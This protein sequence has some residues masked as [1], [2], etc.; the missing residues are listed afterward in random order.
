VK[1]KLLLVG[2]GYPPKIDGG[3]DIHVNH[4]FEELRERDIDVELALPADRAPE[5]DRVIPVETGEGGMIQKTRN[6]SQE[7][8]K[9][10]EE[11]D[12][13]H[14]HDWFGSEAGFKAR[15]YSDVKW[16]STFHSL[17][18]DRTSL[19]SENIERLEKI[20]LKADKPLAVSELLAN[21]IN[22]EYGEKP[23]VV[24]NG[25]SQPEKTGI[26]VKKNLS[27]EGNMVFYVGRHAG[28][29]RI[30]LLIYGFKKLETDAT[31]V[32]GGS[33][34]VTKG[35]K[36]FVQMLG[37]E[38]PGFA[39]QNGDG[40]M[41]SQ[42]SGVLGVTQLLD[43]PL[44]LLHQGRAFH[45][46]RMG[47]QPPVEG[48]LPAQMGNMRAANHDLRGHA[49]GIDAG[50]AQGAAFDQGDPRAA[51]GRLEGRC[52]GRATAADH[53]DMPLAVILHGGEFLEW[54]EP[55]PWRAWYC[56]LRHSA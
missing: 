11:F 9:I 38:E 55:S 30:G 33:G 14:T 20:G 12:I 54:D 24:P 13:I 5:R 7:I 16:V 37:I 53:G 43:S 47:T 28:Q 40:R 4:L 50:A 23:E 41:A 46:R 32:I 49:A 45:P 19:P 21:K 1:Q 15:K 6:M 2:W 44:L 48:A 29:K 25:F 56:F 34:H 31:L 35:L 10:A 51:L 22:E 39:M 27:I 36:N 26:D 8:T 18:S 52:H 42:D 17:S 3:L